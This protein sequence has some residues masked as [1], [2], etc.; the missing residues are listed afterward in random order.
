MR[1]DRPS[2]TAILIALWRGM[3]GVEEPLLAPDAIA[4]R[5]VP[6]LSYCVRAGRDPVSA[7]ALSLI[8]EPIRTRIDPAELAALLA[9]HGFA[10]TSDAGEREWAQRHGARPGSAGAER[11]TVAR[12]RI[13]DAGPSVRTS[14]PGADPP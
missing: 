6:A 2:S 13:G 3:A 10:V 11:I 12:R 9:R 1:R 7:A 14:A 5:L 4:E 8:G